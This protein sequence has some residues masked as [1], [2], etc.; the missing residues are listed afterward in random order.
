MRTVPRI[1]VVQF[2]PKIGQVHA[3]IARAR[4]LCRGIAPRAVDLVCFPEMAF[5]GYVFSGPAHIAPHLEHPRTGPT[6][7]FCAEL[8]SR[9]KCY[10]VAGYPERLAAEEGGPDCNDPTYDA[11]DEN[12]SNVPYETDEDDGH[13][14]GANSAVLF[15][16]DG[17]WVGG[18][19]KTHLFPVD[20]TWAVP[21]TGFATFALPPPL[22]TLAL[23]I[24]MDLNPNPRPRARSNS[25]SSS[26][27]SHSPS[28]SSSSSSSSSS[29]LSSSVSSSSSQHGPP[30]ILRYE[31]ASHALVQRAN[32]LVLLAAWLDSGE[33]PRASCDAS[34]IGYWAH[35]LGPLWWKSDLGPGDGERKKDE[36][37]VVVCN[38]GGVENG[39]R[40]AGSSAVFCMRRGMG[41]AGVLRAAIGREEEGVMLWDAG[42]S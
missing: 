36:T 14:N 2:Q 31:L 19:R 32:V 38:R 16:P 3:N 23:G 26:S 28:P 13:L 25:S 21:G 5:S 29:A 39:K 11:R 22:G 7:R 41:S 17:R 15:G 12:E 27:R 37:L 33:A 24:C 8:A 40:F 6:A 35:R 4:E 30:H 18:Y 20:E 9:L 42:A 1:A 34:T 10:V